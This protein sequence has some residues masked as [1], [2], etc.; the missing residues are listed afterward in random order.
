MAGAIAPARRGIRGGHVLREEVA[1]A[2]AAHEHRADIADGRRHPILRAEC[3]CRAHGDGFLAA[4]AIDA[5]VNFV[6]PHQAPEELFERAIEA[7]VVVEIEGLLAG[8]R[9]AH[10]VTMLGATGEA[11]AAPCSEAARAWSSAGRVT[12]CMVKPRALL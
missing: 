10:G 6:L 7:H 2:K 9:I 5:A 1:G 3:G 8:E 4:A 11:G 12:G